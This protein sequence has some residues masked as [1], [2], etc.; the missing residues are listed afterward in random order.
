M[1]F[2][3]N[4]KLN[5]ENVIEP[6]SRTILELLQKTDV[7][8]VSNLITT[9]KDESVDLANT[10]LTLLSQFDAIILE[11]TDIEQQASYL[12]AQAV[13]QKK[14]TLCL[15]QKNKVPRDLVQ[16]LKQKH[17]PKDVHIKSYTPETV[18][19][20]FKTFLSSINARVEEIE[21]P[22]IRFTLRLTPS[23]DKFLAEVA[24]KQKVTKA[25][26][27]RELLKKT[28]KTNKQ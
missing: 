10:G 12:L 27:L 19:K 18:K 5:S 22:S 8:L 1:R 7:E 20:T 15:Y 26:Y 4:G 11:V 3:F 24:K 17:I 2:L 14:P 23:L 9:N 28:R 13:L 21:I 16:F 25:D 6:G